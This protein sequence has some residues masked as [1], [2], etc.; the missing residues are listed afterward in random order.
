MENEGAGINPDFA[1]YN[2]LNRQATKGCWRCQQLICDDC[3]EMLQGMTYCRKCA[4][5]VEKLPPEPDERSIL[6]DKFPGADDHHHYHHHSHSR[7]RDLRHDQVISGA[8]TLSQ[9]RR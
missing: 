8:H 3:S 9:A 5:E 1:C 6:K 4:A 2:H 7:R